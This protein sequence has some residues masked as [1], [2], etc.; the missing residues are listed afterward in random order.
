MPPSSFSRVSAPDAPAARLATD[1]CPQR[2]RSHRDSRG[3]GPGGE[4]AFDGRDAQGRSCRASREGP[5]AG[6]GHDRAAE[7]RPSRARL[8]RSR[9][10]PTALAHL[11]VAEEYRRAGVL[12]QAFDHFDEALKHDPR[13]AA[14]YDG[15]A[16]IWRDWHIP[17][18][19]LGDSAR[20]VY[21]APR[22]ASARN[23]QGTLLLAIGECAAAR[24]A[25]QKAID[26][27]PAATY[28]RIN[29]QTV[30]QRRQDGAEVRTRAAH[31]R[32]I[33][34]KVTAADRLHQERT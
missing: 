6:C 19:G 20:A 12:D 29:L 10:D 33:A 7:Q 3:T 25:F 9:S 2:I 11:H 15:R 21:F 26:L 18:A 23:T 8:H 34:S 4:G 31:G 14:A 5:R 1:S 28:A 30:N 17:A 13:L 27:D 32:S 16:R 24:S 22:S